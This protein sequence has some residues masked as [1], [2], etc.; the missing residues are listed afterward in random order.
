[1]IEPRFAALSSMD[2]RSK[3]AG[4]LVTV[5]DVDA[6]RLLTRRLTDLPPGAAVVGEEACATDPAL[7]D[8]LGSAWAWLVDPLDGTTNFVEGNPE[9][10]VMVAPCQ[11]G[12]TV[13][14]WIWQPTSQTTYTAEAGDGATRNGVAATVT[15]RAQGPAGLRGAV[16]SRFIPARVSAAVNAGRDRFGAV[17]AGR[18]CAGFDYPAMV[19]GG[20][21][22]VLFLRTL[23]WDHASGT[24][25]LQEAG[26]V[27]RRPNTSFYRP[28]DTAEGLL[29]AADA[30][31]WDTVH[32]GLLA[33]CH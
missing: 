8:G 15:P 5:A 12:R 7:L 1:V 14:S 28:T 13:A 31:I 18:C 10:A 17:T 4:E 22:F 6:E 30:P 23:P 19:D 9:W 25:L 2:V 20:Q 27:A 29:A 11:E 26:G 32:A 33:G 21:D 24:L 16:L 3:E